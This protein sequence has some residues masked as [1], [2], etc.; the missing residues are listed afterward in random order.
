MPIKS[1]NYHTLDLTRPQTNVR[2][3]NYKPTYDNEL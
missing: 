2:Q 1:T 3:D